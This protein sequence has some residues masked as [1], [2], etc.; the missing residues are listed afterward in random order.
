MTP[1]NQIRPI[2]GFYP[3]GRDGSLIPLNSLPPL[4]PVTQ[5]WCAIATDFLRQTVGSDL[6]SVYLRGS[7]ARNAGV[8]Y[9]SDLDFFYL[10]ATPAAGRWTESPYQQDL[11]KR[12]RPTAKKLR[13][14]ELMQAY[15]S[16][17]FLQANPR[18]AMVIAVQSRCIFG[19]P[20]IDPSRRYYPGAEVALYQRWWLEDLNAF[21][22]QPSPSIVSIQ[23]VCKQALRTAFE[24]VMEEANCFT[25]DLFYCTTVAAQFRPE[26]AKAL[27]QLLWCYVHPDGQGATVRT[28]LA[29]WGSHFSTTP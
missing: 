18:V 3:Q 20:M 13:T 22:V 6:Q 15:G 25:T 26:W 28:I 16:P 17:H 5:A 1:T 14:I 29:K 7:Y 10:S 9:H 11:A 24:Q 12:L 4:H 27:W 8:P 23:L 21:F 19:K 2:G